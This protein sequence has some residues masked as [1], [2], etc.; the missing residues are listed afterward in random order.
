METKYSSNEKNTKKVWVKPELEVFEI[1][2]TEHWE[3]QYNPVTGFY[4][5]V[6]VSDYS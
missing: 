6:W 1:K 3:F 4:E 5:N 2:K